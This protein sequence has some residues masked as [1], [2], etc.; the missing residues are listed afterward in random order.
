MSVLRALVPGGVNLLAM[1]MEDLGLDPWVKHHVMYEVQLHTGQLARLLRRLARVAAQPSG[2]PV[3]EWLV[4]RGPLLLLLARMVDPLHLR[5]NAIEVLADPELQ[6]QTQH[7]FNT[8]HLRWDTPHVAEAVVK[9]ALYNATAQQLSGEA[10]KQAV[11]AAAAVVAAAEA[12]DQDEGAEEARAAAARERVAALRQEAARF[13]ALAKEQMMGGA[14]A[15][16]GEAI[17]NF[18]VRDHRNRVLTEEGIFRKQ[19]RA[20]GGAGDKAAAP[21]PQPCTP[22]PMAATTAA[23]ATHGSGMQAAAAEVGLGEAGACVVHGSYSAGG[24]TSSSA[25][26][27]ACVSCLMQDVGTEDSLHSLHGE[28]SS[29]SLAGSAWA[30]MGA[31]VATAMDAEM[32]AGMGPDVGAQLQLADMA[33]SSGQGGTGSGS[34]H[35]AVGAAAAAGST[36]AGSMQADA[37]DEDVDVRAFAA[38]PRV[39]PPMERLLRSM[40]G[41][42]LDED[43]ASALRSVLPPMEPAE[44]VDVE[45]R[46]VPLLSAF[47]QPLQ[48]QKQS[49]MGTLSELGSML[50]WRGRRGAAAA[51]AAPARPAAP[52]PTTA[53]LPRGL[54]PEDDDKEEGAG[55]QQQG[56]AAA[57]VRLG[58]PTLVKEYM[59][60]MTRLV[61]CGLA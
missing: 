17:A 16:C 2:V 13:A 38:V 3:P 10:S 31:G 48:Q 42:V 32:D 6:Q 39:E 61:Y 23:A 7:V 51:A 35:G 56:E 8:L 49:L 44:M 26:S 52:A 57:A 53:P 5:A 58:D 33:R 9:A 25:A 55:A 47:L 50:M 40:N 30:G 19:S 12:D 18:S 36:M 37:A 20:A 14:V 4:G 1:Q 54:A 29:A 11:A 41:S 46:C 22:R 27:D 28:R 45:P 60:A 24:P 15:A 21:Q 43:T 59:D 34:G